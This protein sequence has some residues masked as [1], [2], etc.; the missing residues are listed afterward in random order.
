MCTTNIAEMPTSTS[1]IHYREK[2]NTVLQ[3]LSSSLFVVGHILDGEKEVFI[4]ENSVRFHK[5]E[6][7]F[8]SIGRHYAKNIISKETGM[9]EELMT[10]MSSSDVQKYINQIANNVNA[11]I[12]NPC[13]VCKICSTKRFIPVPEIMSIPLFFTL[14]LQFMGEETRIK[15]ES[16]LTL[17]IPA[18]LYIL[19]TS[20]NKCIK[21]KILAAKETDEDHFKNFICKNVFTDITVEELA[22]E[23]GCSVSSFCKK[24]KSLFGTNPHE[25]IMH[26]RLKYGKFLLRTTAYSVE[27]IS[28]LCCIPNFSHFSQ[29]FKKEYNMTPLQYRSTHS[30]H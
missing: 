21:G 12:E 22:S 14:M 25:W 29:R 17:V 18:L 30:N 7:Y 19:F 24:F 16:I 9:Y 4:G 23:T 5:G 8:L 27:E 2:E 28:K 20:P 11:T 10:T 26:E 13:N 1:I 6:T 3:L 15:D